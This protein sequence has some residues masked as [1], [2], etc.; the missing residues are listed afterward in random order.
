MTGWA[1]LRWA[2]GIGILVALVVTLDAPATIA[3]LKDANVALVLIGVAGLT[4]L[5]LLGAAAWRSLVRQLAGRTLDW[6]PAV[7]HYYAAQAIG[8]L[9]PANVGSDV[10]RVMAVREADGLGGAAQPIVVQRAMSY[11]AVLAV[12]AAALMFAAQPGGGGLTLAVAILV[13]PIIG[14]Q[15]AG[16]IPALRDRPLFPGAV[17]IGLGYGVAFH[18]IG[19]ALTY[20]L[21]LA[22]EPSA[23][24]AAA[25]AAVAVSRVAILVPLTPSGLGVQE[26]VLAV[27]FVSIGLPA[28][29]AL[30]ASLLA[31]LSLLLTTIL[32]AAAVATSPRP[33]QLAVAS[34]YPKSR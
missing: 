33:S 24:S 8:G 27:L 21:V 14:L 16:W 6:R 31:R 25:L 10:Y 23:G 11:L 32:G 19:V 12:A 20:L 34:E 18:V 13:L 5:H 22:V 28:E 30:A 17:R 15:F 4:A 26:T 1:V 9:T 29:L 2:V 7:R 3:L